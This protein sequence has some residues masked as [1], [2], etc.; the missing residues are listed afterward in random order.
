MASKN[1]TKHYKQIIVARLDLRMS[2]GKLATQA[3]HASMAFLTNAMR[4]NAR[5]AD[6]Q[7]VRVELDIDYGLWEGWING[8]FTKVVLG[9]KN[10]ADMDKLLRRA[11]RHGLVRDRDFFCIYDN[12]LTELKAEEQDGTCLTCVGFRPMTD[13][14]IDPVTKR[15][16]LYTG[17]NPLR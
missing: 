15:V 12:C 6:S 4:K 1:D 7:T 2:A 16:R 8:I 17:T 13:E 9:V 10:K 3:S 5:R 11:E 14:E